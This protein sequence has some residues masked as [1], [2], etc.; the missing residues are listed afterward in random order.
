VEKSNLLKWG[1]PKPV[2]APIVDT[3]TDETGG[4]YENVGSVG[5]EGKLIWWME[6]VVNMEE[7]CRRVVG[8]VV[9]RVVEDDTIVVV[10]NDKNVI[11]QYPDIL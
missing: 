4:P 11:A 1:T 3:D 2:C 5:C 6:R 7:M 9:G 10:E 8:S